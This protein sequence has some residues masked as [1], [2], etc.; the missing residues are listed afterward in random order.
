MAVI[1]TPLPHASYTTLRNCWLRDPRISLKAKGLLG[2]LSS[3]S[4]HY[5]CSQ[6][7]MIAESDDGRAAVRTALAELE[8]A[9]YLTRIPMR[10]AGRYA[11]DDYTLADPFDAAGHLLGAET[12]PSGASLGAE[13]N[14]RRFSDAEKQPREITPLEDQEKKTKEQTPLPEEGGQGRRP[15]QVEGGHPPRRPRQDHRRGPRVPVRPHPHEVRQT[16]R[17]LAA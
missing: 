12:A 6:A 5:R 3:H 4:E 13:I 17:H 8:D 10:S 2:Y 11:E 7:Q 1:R 9:G 15:P 16:T 14:Q